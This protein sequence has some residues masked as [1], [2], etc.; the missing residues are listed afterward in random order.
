MDNAEKS[1][2]AVEN[3]NSFV[4]KEYIN[5]NTF[6]ASDGG[7]MRG[8]IENKTVSVTDLMDAA[9]KYEKIGFKK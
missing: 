1:K 9:K 2:D 5:S 8:L 6:F 4:L 7:D 3:Y